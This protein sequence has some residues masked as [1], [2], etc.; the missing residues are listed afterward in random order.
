MAETLT[1]LPIQ[2]DKDSSVSDL[3]FVSIVCAFGWIAR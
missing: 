1:G 3:S 2:I